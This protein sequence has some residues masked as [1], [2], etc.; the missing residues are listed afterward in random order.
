MQWMV[1]RNGESGSGAQLVH[2]S[3]IPGRQVG[4]LSLH[5]CWGSRESLNINIPEQIVMISSHSLKVQTSEKLHK[6]VVVCLE[7]M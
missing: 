6:Q 1:L 5:I 3:Q 2:A 7:V 4:A